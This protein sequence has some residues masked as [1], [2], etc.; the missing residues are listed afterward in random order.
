MSA[1]EL[2][3]A[4]VNLSELATTVGDEIRRTLPA[5]RTV[6]F[7]VQPGLGARG[8]A[9]LL[10]VVL[11]NLVANAAKFTRSSAKAR[12]EVGS[13]GPDTD[14]AFF[15]ADNGVGLDMRYADELF[16][17]FERPHDDPSSEGTGI[18]LATVRRIVERHGGRLWAES[19]PGRGATFYF[20]LPR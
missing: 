14:P 18:G 5:D 6:E 4:N 16:G 2:R 13:R 7:V 17:A 15:V 8:D 3:R 19:E 9:R 10:R 1:A 20:T 12:I 11:N